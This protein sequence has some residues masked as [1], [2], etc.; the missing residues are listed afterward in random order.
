MVSSGDMIKCKCK[1]IEITALAMRNF[2]SDREKRRSVVS[3]YD[4]MK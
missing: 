1:D 2:F 3:V 4:R